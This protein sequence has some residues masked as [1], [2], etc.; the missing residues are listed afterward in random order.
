MFFN[1]RE[2]VKHRQLLNKLSA[3][4]VHLKNHWDYVSFFAKL[5]PK[6]ECIKNNEERLAMLKSTMDNELFIH[7]NDYY[8]HRA[9]DPKSYNMAKVHLL[10][11]C[12][13]MILE[14][15]HNDRNE[16]DQDSWSYKCVEAFQQG[17]EHL[18]KNA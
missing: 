4:K 18:L 10:A 11:Y 8:P 16:V 5:V 7:L 14:R 2:G 13:A 12:T 17:D 9:E 3:N 15:L 6:I 1:S